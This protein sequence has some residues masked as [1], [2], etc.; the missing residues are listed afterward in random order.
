MCLICFLLEFPGSIQKAGFTQQ[1]TLLR[2]KDLQ[3]LVLL[4]QGC[5]TFSPSVA[6]HYL[7][8]LSSGMGPF[9]TR[10]SEPWLV[11]C[12][13]IDSSCRILGTI[14]ALETVDDEL[15][16]TPHKIFNFAQKDWILNLRPVTMLYFQY[17][18][19]KEFGSA[20]QVWFFSEEIC[21][22]SFGSQFNLNQRQYYYLYLWPKYWNVVPQF[23]AKRNAPLVRRLDRVFPD[24]KGD[25]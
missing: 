9:G 21:I 11:N 6:V 24:P 1:H 2:S 22:Y 23:H 15:E 4:K 3:G 10:I 19:P 18:R 17:N 5:R 7:T 25:A 14:A 16:L 13:A 12:A 8:L 20:T